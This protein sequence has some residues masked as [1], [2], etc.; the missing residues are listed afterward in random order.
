MVYLS[1]H[2][3]YGSAA[4]LATKAHDDRLRL[5]EAAVALGHASEA[6]FDRW[7]R[8]RDMREPR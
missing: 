4:E 7:V 6:D 8:P 5:K 2:T 3:G 1:P